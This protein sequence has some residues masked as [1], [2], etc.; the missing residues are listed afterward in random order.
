MAKNIVNVNELQKKSKTH[1]ITF[2][3]ESGSTG[4]FRVESGSSGKFY[5]VTQSKDAY[6]PKWGCNCKWAEFQPQSSSVAC[7][8]VQKVVAHIAAEDGYKIKV[9]LV[10]EDT[11]HLH[12]KEQ[13]I[14]HNVKITLRG[15]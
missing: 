11:K 5:T 15:D 10:D 12:R 6:S 7:S 2:I 9:R 13:K 14:N 4:Y 3:R 8:H 1:N